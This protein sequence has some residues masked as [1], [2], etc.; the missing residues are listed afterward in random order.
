MF[1]D[2]DARARWAFAICVPVSWPCYPS[3]GAGGELLLK[4]GELPT[5]K[6]LVEFQASL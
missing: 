6:A 1:T 3:I 4:S 5:D 2:Q